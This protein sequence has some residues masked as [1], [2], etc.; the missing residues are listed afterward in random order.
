MPSPL[1]IPWI[2]WG[3]TLAEVELCTLETVKH[4]RKKLRTTSP[5]GSAVKNPLAWQKAQVM[6]FQFLDGEDLLE[7]GMAAHPNILP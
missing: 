5:S 2:H 3:W 1:R 6:Q 7:E 4:D